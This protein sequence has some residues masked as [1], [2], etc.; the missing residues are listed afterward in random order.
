MHSFIGRD[1]TWDSGVLRPGLVTTF[2]MYPELTPIRVASRSDG[3]AGHEALHRPVDDG[4]VYPPADRPTVEN[5]PDRQ[6]EG[7]RFRCKRMRFRHR[8]KREDGFADA[9]QPFV[10]RPRVALLQPFP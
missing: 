5:A 6:T 2:Y 1:L 7:L 4:V 8:P 3:H 10:R 9:R